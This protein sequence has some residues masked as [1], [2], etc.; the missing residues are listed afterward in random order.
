MMYICVSM[1]I[2]HH[3]AFII[4]YYTSVLFPQLFSYDYIQ[5]FYIMMANVNDMHTTAVIY[6]IT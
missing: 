2:Y 4:N 1:L 6:T 5:I 3:T